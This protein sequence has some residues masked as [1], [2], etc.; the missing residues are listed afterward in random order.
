MLTTI[1]NSLAVNKVSCVLPFSKINFEIARIL[2]KNEFIEDCSKETVVDEKF[3]SIKI[4]LK[5]DINSTPAI[6]EIKRLSKLG[7]RLYT[8]YADI[9]VPRFGI[10]ILSTPKGMMTSAKAKSQKIGGETI[11][12]VR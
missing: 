7:R 5:Y 9:R 8:G 1:R 4:L 12:S 3:K 11:C 6:T 10:I 2:K